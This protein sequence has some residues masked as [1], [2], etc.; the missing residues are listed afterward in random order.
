MVDRLQKQQHFPI[1]RVIKITKYALMQKLILFYFLRIIS[2]WSLS[3][4]PSKTLSFDDIEQ[5]VSIHTF[6]YRHL[7]VWPSEQHS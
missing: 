6:Y 4:G 2:A 5:A 1:E 3:N 7:V